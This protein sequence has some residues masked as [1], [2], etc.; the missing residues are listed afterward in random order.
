MT[1]VVVGISVVRAGGLRAR[2]RDAEGRAVARAV[3]RRRGTETTG[4]MG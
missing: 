2:T 1:L 4:E 3:G